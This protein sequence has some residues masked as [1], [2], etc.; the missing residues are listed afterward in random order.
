MVTEIILRSEAEIELRFFSKK[1][2]KSE[3]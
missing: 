2:I 3:L 1:G